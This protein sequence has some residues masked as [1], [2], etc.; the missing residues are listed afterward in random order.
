[1]NVGDTIQPS[2]K[3][4]SL[5]APDTTLFPPHAPWGT[6]HRWA[7][8]GPSLQPPLGAGGPREHLGQLRALGE[9]PASVE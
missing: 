6:Q 8:P 9:H 4:P 7:G 5:S 1:M 3:G 2:S